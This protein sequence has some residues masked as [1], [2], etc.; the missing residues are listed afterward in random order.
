MVG[1]IQSELPR[2]MQ[3]AAD[4]TL[5]ATK[6]YVPVEFGG[7]LESGKAEAIETPR[8]VIARV[9]FGGDTPVTPTPNAPTGFVTYAAVVN[10]D[11]EKEHRVGE[12]MF[13]EKGAFASKDEVDAYIRAELAK[14]VL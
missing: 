13:L 11:L 6:P 5:E 4:M 9:S 10:Y 1:V 2:I 12:A 14:V 7:L 3:G 8:G